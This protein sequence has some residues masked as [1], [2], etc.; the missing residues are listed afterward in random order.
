MLHWFGL[1]NKDIVHNM[2]KYLDFVIFLIKTGR[3]KN[4]GNYPKEFVENVF[5]VTRGKIDLSLAKLPQ[6]YISEVKQTPNHK[7]F[8]GI[9]TELPDIEDY[10]VDV[11]F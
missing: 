11:G 10:A 6:K 2:Q 3:E 4:V 1:H 8:G 9:E 5:H 7:Q